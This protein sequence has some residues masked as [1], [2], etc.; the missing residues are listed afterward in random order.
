MKKCY[1]VIGAGNGGIAMAGYLAL[2]GFKVNLYNRTKERIK[3][4]MKD[5]A[6]NSPLWKVRNA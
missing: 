3:L 4:L 2:Q 6:L 5:R 1:A